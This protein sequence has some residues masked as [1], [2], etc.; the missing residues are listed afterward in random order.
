MNKK[1]LSFL[2][3]LVVALLYSCYSNSQS[4]KPRQ[5]LKKVVAS[6]DTIH[7]VTYKISR[8]I[9]PFS[10][11]DT[12]QD[13]AICSLYLV[14]KDKMKAYHIVDNKSIDQNRY[15]HYIYDGNHTATFTYRTDSLNISKKTIIHS[16]ANNNHDNVPGM[17]Y[18]IVLR[19]VFQ[20]KNIFREFKSLKARFFI[21]KMEVEEDTYLNTP[22]YILS[23]YGKDRE[24]QI[25]YINNEVYKFYIRK[26]DFLPIAYSNYGEL[27]GM[28]NYDYYELKYLEINPKLSLND[29]KIDT[30]VNEIE[31]KVY[32]ENL[33]KFGIN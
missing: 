6:L 19:D 30:K 2:P 7:T 9:K 3:I 24:G 31:P 15:V 20:R 18:N 17:A 12:I 32:Y 29:F 1:C 10:L 8:T 13:V 16:V 25:D 5:L 27:E 11:R 22:I 26:S 23:I 14:S 21:K 33:Q 4:I 28:K